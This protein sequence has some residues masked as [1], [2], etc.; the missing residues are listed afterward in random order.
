MHI[1][2]VKCTKWFIIAEYG[3]GLEIPIIPAVILAKK[4]IR[5]QFNKSGAMLC[6]DLVTLDEYLAE[7]KGLAIQVYCDEK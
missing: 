7:L 1:I 6:I 5:D 2:L 3:E 4:I